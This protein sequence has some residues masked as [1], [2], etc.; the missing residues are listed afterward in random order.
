M[1]VRTDLS[2]YRLTAGLFVARAVVTKD[3]RPDV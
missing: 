1:M 2:R 3:R